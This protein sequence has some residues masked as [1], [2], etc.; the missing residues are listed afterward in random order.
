MGVLLTQ[1]SDGHGYLAYIY[2]FGKYD[3]SYRCASCLSFI[4]LAQ[5]KIDCC[6]NSFRRFKKKRP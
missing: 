2:V 1:V 3:R 6:I 5:A 4:V